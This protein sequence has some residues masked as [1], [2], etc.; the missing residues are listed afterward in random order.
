MEHGV[1]RMTAVLLSQAVLVPNLVGTFVFALSGGVAGVKGRVD[2]FGLA[3][4]AFAAGNAGGIMR[5]MI[6]G[7]FPAGSLS[8]W[9][10]LAVSVLAAVVVFL[11]YPDIDRRR[12]LVLY[13]DAGGLALF[14]VTGTLAALSVG[15]GPVM[16]PVMGMLTGI[17]G[18]MLRDVLVNETPAVLKSDLYAIAALAAGLVVVVGDALGWPWLATFVV[19]AGLCFFLRMMAIHRGWGLPTAPW[20]S[21]PG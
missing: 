3:V 17:G 13:F 2:L 16:A 20:S 11:W 21:G 12:R 1:E 4:L 5:D 18:G 10:Y 9:R 19:G 7:R 8:D 14:A 15:L 6:L